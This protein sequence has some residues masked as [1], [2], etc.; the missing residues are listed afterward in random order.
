MTTKMNW[1][2]NGKVDDID[3][4]THMPPLNQWHL[5]SAGS[6]GVTFHCDCVGDVGR[7]VIAFMAVMRPVMDAWPMTTTRMSITIG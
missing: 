3:D 2:I 5:H 7:A 1:D 6:E 4:D